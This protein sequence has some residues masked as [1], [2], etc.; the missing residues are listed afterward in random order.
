MS[1]SVNGPIFIKWNEIE[2]HLTPEM[3]RMYDIWNK[4]NM[5]FGMPG[6]RAWDDQPLHIMKIIETCERE[7]RSMR[8]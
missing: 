8:A 5:G 1:K 6:G 7:Y 2:G 3:Y 4:Y